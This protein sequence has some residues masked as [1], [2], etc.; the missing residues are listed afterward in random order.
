MDLFIE[1]VIWTPN[2]FLFR[3]FR[4]DWCLDG[5]FIRR[6]IPLIVNWKWSFNFKKQCTLSLEKRSFFH[7]ENSRTK[8]AKLLLCQ[9]QLCIFVCTWERCKY[10]V[11]Y[12]SEKWYVI[13]SAKNTN[14]F[15]KSWSILTVLFIWTQSFFSRG[16]K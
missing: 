11:T 14:H 7:S 15:W 4:N 6:N 3:N 8:T 10:L 1:N 13:N 5:T 9:N 12:F 16:K 2:C